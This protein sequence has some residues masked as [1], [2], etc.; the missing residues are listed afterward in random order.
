[1]VPPKLAMVTEEKRPE[2]R[3]RARKP[4]RLGGERRTHEEEEVDEV[5]GDVDG[6]AA[7]VLLRRGRGISGSAGGVLCE[8]DLVKYCFEV[9]SLI[10]TAVAVALVIAL[11]LPRPVFTT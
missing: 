3:R 4:P 2:R 11:R 8:L 5:G 10:V 1:M 9:T 7:E 6:G